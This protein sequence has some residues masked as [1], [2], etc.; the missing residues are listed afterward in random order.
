MIAIY[1]IFF[2]D[3]VDRESFFVER[4][5]E[6]GSLFGKKSAK[7][8]GK[9]ISTFTMSPIARKTLEKSASRTSA[10]GNR[11]SRIRDTDT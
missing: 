8:I 1:K 11:R 5:D 3:C 9:M 4:R 10:K 6:V 2:P 7:I